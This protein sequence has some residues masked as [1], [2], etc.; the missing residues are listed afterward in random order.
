MKWISLHFVL[1]FSISVSAQDCCEFNDE[2]RSSVK[3]LGQEFQRLRKDKNTACCNNFGSG[4]MKVMG[5]LLDSVN[6]GVTESFIIEVM[7][8]PN[9]YASKEH[10]LEHHFVQLEEDERVII[11]FWR[12]LHDFLYFGFKN[13]Q[14]IYKNWYYALE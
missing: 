2:K 5:I 8:K 6:T 12:G 7:G 13:D 4:L 1:F 9:L 10:P 11:Y 14:L 3:E